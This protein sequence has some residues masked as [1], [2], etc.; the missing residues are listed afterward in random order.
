LDVRYNIGIRDVN[1]ASNGESVK[2]QVFMVSMGW[3]F[4]K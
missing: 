3:N 2:S 4:L 1:N